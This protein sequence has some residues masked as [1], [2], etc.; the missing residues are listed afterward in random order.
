MDI[1]SEVIGGIFGGLG[2]IGSLIVVAIVLFF[3]IAFGTFLIVVPAHLAR[4][5]EALE[6]GSDQSEETE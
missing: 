6:K 4:I 2:I 5:A 3:L 1:F